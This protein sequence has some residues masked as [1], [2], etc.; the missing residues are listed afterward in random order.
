MSSKYGFGL[1]GCGGI[2][3]TH[4]R[5][6]RSLDNVHL[7]AVSDV[8]EQAA[9]AKGEQEDVPWYVDYRELL[10]RD[11]ID[12]VNVVTPSGTHSD[13]IQAA[14]RAGK[15]VIVEKPIDISF[16]KAV[17]AVTA[18]H[19][20]GVK[21]CVVSQHRFD[22]ASRVVRDAILSKRFGN[23]FQANATVNW[24]RA[25][26]YYERSLGA[27][28]LAM[29]GGGVFM[30]QAYHM[31]D[32]L[33]YLMGPVRNV[34]SRTQIATHQNVEVEDSAVAVLEFANGALGT[35]SGTTGAFPGFAT[36]VETFGSTG[37]AVI[38]NDELTHFYTKDSAD[39]ERMF[40]VSAQNRA[41]QIRESFTET[42]YPYA[43]RLQFENFIWAIDQ[44]REPLVN[45]DEALQTLRLILSMY[46][47]AHT[48]SPVTILEAPGT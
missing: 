15:H 22:N 14:A 35:V 2:S 39:I 4:I 10:E 18:C 19:E 43:F 36:K 26:A 46:E 21:L 6:L 7:V 23:V 31:I 12:A 3:T 42:A 28:T 24:Y 17:A 30:I 38:E 13:I 37:S 48:G 44:N 9:K 5:V 16:S 8:S 1:I 47:S 41:K 32:L 27:G 34:Y 40:G 29:D 20:T 33:L 45:G 25:Q 11:D